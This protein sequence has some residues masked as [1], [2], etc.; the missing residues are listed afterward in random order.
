MEKELDLTLPE[1]VFLD[2]HSHLGDTLEQRVLLQHIQSYSIVEF[3]LL[4]D[5]VVINPDMKFKE[6]IYKN[7]YGAEEKHLIV[8]HFSLAAP[9]ELDWM[10]ERAIEF[11]KHFL[12]W[13]DAS[14]II[15]ETSKEN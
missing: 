14:L 6:F 2:G 1:W 9:I 10:L 11:Y 3:I 15:E 12:D 8:V 5:G 13:Q 4:E 7:I